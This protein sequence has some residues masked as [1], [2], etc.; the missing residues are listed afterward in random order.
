MK[1][2]RGAKTSEKE[3]ERSREYQLLRGLAHPSIITV[4]ERFGAED[5]D[6]K[7]AKQFVA[8]GSA[9]FGF[10]LA[11]CSM[12]DML[13]MAAHGGASTPAQ[14]SASTPDSSS[15]AFSWAANVGSV[16]SYLHDQNIIHR[17]VKPANI[18]LFWNP[19]SAVGAGYMQ[20]KAKL[21][22]FG[23][24]RVMPHTRR[25]KEASPDRQAARR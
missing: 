2:G 4:V 12:K 22:D 14:S 9:I 15:L 21:A 23:L 1:L 24:A 25:H 17:D 10:E 20:T 3:I 16:L 19:A 13:D 18:L 6:H 5:M 8:R 11:A 7:F